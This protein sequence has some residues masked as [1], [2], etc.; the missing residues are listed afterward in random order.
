VK[1]SAIPPFAEGAKDGPPNP[2]W[3][4]KKLRFSTGPQ[5]FNTKRLASDDDQLCGLFSVR[6]LQA[7]EQAVRT[8]SPLLKQFCQERAHSDEAADPASPSG[9]L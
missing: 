4:G 6:R 8:R 9:P 5:S 1:S 3:Q 7:G 2:S